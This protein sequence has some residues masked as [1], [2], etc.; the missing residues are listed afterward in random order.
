MDGFSGGGN[1]I[2]PGMASLMAEDRNPYIGRRERHRPDRGAHPGVCRAQRLP[3]V[4]PP[5]VGGRAGPGGEVLLSWRAAD[6]PTF[7]GR[8]ATSPSRRSRWCGTGSTCRRACS[9]LRARATA[10]KPSTR[11]GSRDPASAGVTEADCRTLRTTPSTRPSTTARSPPADRDRRC[12]RIVPAARGHARD[13]P[14]QRVGTQRPIAIPRIPCRSPWRPSRTSPANPSP[15]P[16]WT[17]AVRRSW[18]SR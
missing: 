14:D 9:P 18:R 1:G 15:P 10:A 5:R 4:R 13:P 6:S 17:A 2:R 11:R 3:R 8:A 16:R 12:S 7:L